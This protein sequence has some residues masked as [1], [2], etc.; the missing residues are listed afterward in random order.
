MAAATTPQIK[1]LQVD[2]Y[3]KLNLTDLYY[4]YGVAQGK[5]LGNWE[6]KTDIPVFVVGDAKSVKYHW[7]DENNHAAGIKCTVLI[8]GRS[9]DGSTDNGD[10]VG[11]GFAR[12]D[13]TKYPNDTYTIG[14]A[15]GQHKNIQDS[16]TKEV[17]ATGPI[18]RFK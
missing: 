3:G 7:F 6:V 10:D 2:T 18:C 17:P 8:E 9:Y 1:T 13:I 15:V 11:E 5:E 12:V 14:A 16:A 4:V